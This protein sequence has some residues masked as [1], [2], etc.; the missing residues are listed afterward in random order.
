MREGGRKERKQRKKEREGGKKK[1][2]RSWNIL[3]FKNEQKRKNWGYN[4][5][6]YAL[7]ILR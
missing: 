3:L 2:E 5:K 6:L 4:F 1:K 7:E